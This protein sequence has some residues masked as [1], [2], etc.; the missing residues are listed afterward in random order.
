M[1]QPLMTIPPAQA[2]A[3]FDTELE[4]DDPDV[5]WTLS[6]ATAGE[7]DDQDPFD[8]TDQQRPAFARGSGLQQPRLQLF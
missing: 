2:E 7:W 5:Q 1:K 6:M 8:D 3:L 4:N